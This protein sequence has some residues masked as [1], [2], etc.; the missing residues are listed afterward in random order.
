MAVKF[1]NFHSVCTR[2]WKNEKFTLTKKFLPSK[3]LIY[4]VNALL[5]RNFC[6]KSVRVDFR[7]GILPHSFWQK[8][9]ESN[10]FTNY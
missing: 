4:L 6:Q 9:R 10:G 1:C 7:D 2:L 5:S 8:F 3:Q